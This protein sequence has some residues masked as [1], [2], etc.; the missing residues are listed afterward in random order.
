MIFFRSDYSQGA[1]PKVMEAL[2]RTNTEH[3]DG[4][5]LDPHCAHAADLIRA[6]TSR[7][8]AAVHMMVGGIRL[9]LRVTLLPS[10]EAERSVTSGQTAVVKL[11]VSPQS[12]M[13]LLN[14]SQRG[15]TET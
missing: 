1:H 7:E 5:A 13:I 6:L 11:M 15:R 8:D 12:P 9:H 14:K 10:T 4:Y 3:T 2:L